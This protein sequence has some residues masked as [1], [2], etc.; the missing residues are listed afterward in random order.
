MKIL[1][2]ALIVSM[3]ALTSYVFGDDDVG[4]ADAAQYCEMVKLNI[5]TNGV[6]GWPDYKGTYAGECK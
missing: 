6:Y 1:I 5:K 4:Q 2:P 3:L